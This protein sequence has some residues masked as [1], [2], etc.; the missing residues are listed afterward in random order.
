MPRPPQPNDRQPDGLFRPA[1]RTQRPSKLI[2]LSEEPLANQNDPG[3]EAAKR[4]M[5]AAPNA[6]DLGLDHRTL[7]DAIDLI[8]DVPFQPAMLM[9]SAIAA[10]LY[11]HPRDLARQLELARAIAP[12]AVVAAIEQFIADDP[13][14]HVV[15]DPRYV[16]A[17]Q[18]VLIVHAAEDPDPPR[19]MSDR[20]M[21]QVAFALFALGSALPAAVPPELD[22]TTPDWR[23]WTNFIMQSSGWYH[24]SYI[25]EAVARSY[26]MFA[27]IAKSEQLRNHHARSEVDERMRQV[28]GLDLT[29]Q[30]GVGLGSAA[31]SR[32]AEPDLA[33]ERRPDI[34]PGFLGEATL[35]DREDEVIKLISASR[36]ELR[37]ALLAQGDTPERIAWDHSILE[38]HPFV[39]LPDKRMRLTSPRSLVAWMTRGIHYRLLDAAG[40][41]LD[42]RS[43]HEARGLFLTFT[44][45]L[46]EGYVRRVTDASLKIA[47]RA[48]AVRL[49]PEVEFRVGKQRLDGPD[50]P[51]DAGPDLILI[52]VYSGRMSIPART[53]ADPTALAEFVDRATGE[54]LVELAD[55]TRNLLAG[56]LTYDGLELGVVRRI[57]PVL[58]L[59]GESAM[60]QPLLWGH[61]RDAFP[62]AFVDDGRVQR[63]MVCD[64]DDLEP[65]LALAE[66]GHHLPEL[67]AAF[68]ESEFA[69]LAP[70]SWVVHRFEEAARPSYVENQ[71]RAA[72]S[73]AGARLFRRD[74]VEK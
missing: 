26:T 55:R 64:L 45:A 72:L 48:G 44:G 70:R 35:T 43:A 30:I 12:A 65:L 37:A 60:Q 21:T 74:D 23:G 50:V 17:L 52:E 8:V 7:P 19:G 33:P 11:H 15:F 28:Y 27:D 2:V 34:G 9:A 63:P 29:E 57:F 68:L 5:L 24:D 14:D 46:G 25:L 61:L 58:V 67:L 73:S 39:R 62:T 6:E 16:H 1:H 36:N 59:A 20:E 38:A 49:W 53:G 54:K 41:G 71:F 32:A 22:V 51:I 31:V 56:E 13:M 66:Q 40:Q 18:R 3:V 10:E 4:A 47:Q 69:E 42:R